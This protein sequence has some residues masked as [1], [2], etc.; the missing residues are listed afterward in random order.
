[1]YSEIDGDFEDVAINTFKVGLPTE[2][3]L[4]KSLTGK[5]VTS[6]HQLMDWIDKY[7]RVKKDQQLRK[8]KA[9]VILQEMRNFR[10][11]QFNNNRPQRDYTGQSG[12]ANTQVVNAVFRESVHQVLEKIYNDPFFKWSKKMAGNPTRRNQSLYCQYH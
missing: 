11:N 9:K 10:S 8:G 6:V 1:M 7:K 4:R 12:P 5:P 3:G 2:H